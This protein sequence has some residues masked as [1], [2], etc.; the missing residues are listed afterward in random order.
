MYQYEYTLDPSIATKFSTSESCTV[1][2][3]AMA[4]LTG[5]TVG[6]VNHRAVYLPIPLLVATSPRQMKPDGLTW[7]RIL[8]MTGQPNPPRRVVDKAEEVEIEYGIDFIPLPE[9]S[10]H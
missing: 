5:F 2:H 3:G 8:S 9:T 1:Q 7:Q 10:A 6:Q 4:G